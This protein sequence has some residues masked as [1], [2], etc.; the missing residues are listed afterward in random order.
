MTDRGRVLHAKLKILIRTRLNPQAA[1]PSRSVSV[2]V[3][4]MN[5]VDVALEQQGAFPQECVVFRVREKL[6]D[7]LDVLEDVVGVIW[8]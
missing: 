4:Y 5:D 3:S 1:S 6:P 7:V 8:C 2:S